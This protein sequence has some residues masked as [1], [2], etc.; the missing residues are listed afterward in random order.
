MERKKKLLT[1][2]FG[3]LEHLP[4]QKPTNQN[5]QLSR[6]L[7]IV[8]KTV[9]KSKNMGFQGI[10]S[11]WKLFKNLLHSKFQKMAEKSSFMVFR[12][13]F[14]LKYI[15]NQDDLLQ[16]EALA[17]VLLEERKLNISK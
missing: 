16:G 5:S 2:I 17:R 3:I 7:Q 10:F 13:L 15:S 8:W 14:Y 6:F 9:R 11:A 1:E 4:A 12:A